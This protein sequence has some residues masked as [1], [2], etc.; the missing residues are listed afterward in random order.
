MKILITNDDGIFAP[1]MIPF[2]RWAQTIGD[3]T[4]I[5]PK[6]EQSGKSH[7]IELRKTFE[8]DEVDL[9]PGIRALSVDSTPADCIRF[10]V[11][12]LHEHFDLVLS[13]INKGYN[14]GQDMIY[15]GTMGAASEAAYQG[16]NAV[17]VST[18]PDYYPR[19]VEH[20]DTVWDYF[21]RNRLLD[22]HS[23]YNV[24]IPPEAGDIHITGQGGP[25]YSDQFPGEGG[26]LYKAHGRC[27]YEPGT[28][29]SVD[30]HCVMNGHISITPVSTDRT[31]R[32]VFGL[33]QHCR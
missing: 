29:L 24:N 20:L 15:S 27:I 32:A 8:V 3:V 13:G 4:V 31:N 30:T 7:G 33:L 5:A 17:A 23:L 19:A 10:A 21:C 2:A 12:G 11:L 25:Y 6:V 18:D 1:G 28:D 16:L 9:G 26:N 22:M 14:M